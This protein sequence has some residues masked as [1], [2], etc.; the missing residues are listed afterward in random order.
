MT[1]V[2]WVLLVIHD[3]V[4]YPKSLIHKGLS[5]QIQSIVDITTFISDLNVLIDNYSQLD[6][7]Q[8]KEMLIYQGC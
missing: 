7:Y 4:I 8:N 6:F 2:D 5:I 3:S 1:G